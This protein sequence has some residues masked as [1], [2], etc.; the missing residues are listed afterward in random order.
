MVL[1]SEGLLGVE[2]DLSSLGV[3]EDLSSLALNF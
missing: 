1:F 3:E 2:E